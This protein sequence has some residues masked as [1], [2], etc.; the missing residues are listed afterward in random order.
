M[1]RNNWRKANIFR[2]AI[3][4]FKPKKELPVRSK[5]MA[6]KVPRPKTSINKLPFTIPPAVK[7]PAIARY[8]SPH[9]IKPFRIPI[10]KGFFLNRPL[11][12][13]VSHLL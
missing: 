10:R 13:P 6:G 4:R 2:K 12:L 5:N 7:A 1:P 3:L 8:T 9:G 11:K